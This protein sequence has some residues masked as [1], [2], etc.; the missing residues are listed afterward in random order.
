MCVKS[1]PDAVRSCINFTEYVRVYVSVWLF[2]LQLLN[3]FFLC[4]DAPVQYLCQVGVPRSCSEGRTIYFQSIFY[5]FK[6]SSRSQILYI[7]LAKITVISRQ[8]VA[9]V[10]QFPTNHL[11][12]QSFL[13][14][15]CLRLFQC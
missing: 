14:L 12:F 10:K 2:G 6:F 15:L 13:I 11:L 1:A 3:C 9:E 7:E 5:D 4:T 8:L